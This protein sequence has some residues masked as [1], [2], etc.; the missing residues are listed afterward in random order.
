MAEVFE[1]FGAE[2][3]D[4]HGVSAPQAKVMS[5]VLNCRT[6]VLGGQVL[7][8]DGCGHREFAYHSC[9]DRHC[10]ACQAR[11]KEEWTRRRVAELLPVPYAHLVFTL[12][13]ALNGLAAAH[14]LWV[15]GA[16]M[17]T[18][19]ETLG[20]F[21][22]N[23][24]WLGAEPAFTC[25]LHT[26]T[27]DLRRHVHLHVLIACGGLDGAGEW[28][29][30]KRDGRFLFPVHALSSVFRAK[31]L[32][33]L[34]AARD[35]SKI[36]R[37]PA[38]EAKGYAER[39]RRLLKHKWVVY[40]KTPL[41]GPA[42]VLGYLSRYTH[43]TAVSNERILAIREGQVLLRVRADGKGGKKVVRI[44][45][46]DFIGRFLQ[47]VLPPGLKRIRHYG[48]LSP[49]RKRQRLAAARKAL[50]APAPSPV[51]MEAAAEFMQRVA[52]IDIDKC[53]CC[54][55]GRLRA[56]AVLLPEQPATSRPWLAPPACRGPPT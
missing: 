3:L 9:R 37:D 48:L 27:Q 54:G 53:P 22:A 16:L 10:P 20:E 41:G 29:G 34:D 13:H 33:A 45:G 21:A 52:K 36:P 14:G 47:H 15:Y 50:D 43:R 32:D 23:P 8:C 44:D 5:A 39:R 17:R 2:Y 24:R 30:P 42:E 1:A 49:A 56:V 40:A 4:A 35:S 51:A 19:A 18:V 55:Q 26:W 12:P 11:A 31:F 46:P 7:E 25:V 28:V 38:A 6:P